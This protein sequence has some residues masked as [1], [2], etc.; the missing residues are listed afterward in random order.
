MR[1][2]TALIGLLLFWSCKDDE[3]LITQPYVGYYQLENV[4]VS[5]E[6]ND[7]LSKTPIVVDLQELGF[8]LSNDFTYT[9]DTSFI[10]YFFFLKPGIALSEKWFMGVWSLDDHLGILSTDREF[11]SLSLDNNFF[12][13]ERLESNRIKFSTLTNSSMYPVNDQWYF[14]Q[15]I[16]Q[17]SGKL[18]A[19]NFSAGTT[20][21][22]GESIGLTYGYYSGYHNRYLE[23]SS[24]LI[25]EEDPID[26]YAIGYLSQIDTTVNQNTVFLN[27]FRNGLVLGITQGE[28]DADLFFT[29]GA[30][31]LDFVFEYERT[32]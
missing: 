31:S 16:G 25:V 12:Y 21:S 10:D 20:I 17:D 29:E 9:V 14:F 19:Q 32:L 23:L 8:S 30:K 5:Y 18:T 3:E 6:G 26:Q 24:G 2:W 1:R 7:L 13:L 27:G 15:A 4:S 22:E 11:I 28:L